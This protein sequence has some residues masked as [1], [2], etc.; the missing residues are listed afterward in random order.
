MRDLVDTLYHTLA[1]EW[2]HIGIYL[3]LPMATLNTI[4]TE[5][6]NDPH[7]CLIEMLEVWLK[8]VDPPPT[9]PAIIEAIE[10]LGEMQLGKILREKYC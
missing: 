3:H 5:H 9:W 10:F 1:D 6:Q 2:K 7:R 8:R 4:A